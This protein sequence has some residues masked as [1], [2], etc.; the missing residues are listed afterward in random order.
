MIL[1]VI[2]EVILEVILAVILEVILEVMQ[3][4]L[5]LRLGGEV[6]EG[7]FLQVRRGPPGKVQRFVRRRS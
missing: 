1:K 7:E 2:Q 5:H 3:G 6:V 4:V